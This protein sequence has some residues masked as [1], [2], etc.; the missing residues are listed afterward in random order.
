MNSRRTVNNYQMW[1]INH[2]LFLHP[3]PRF[4]MK[5]FLF[6][7]S[8]QS[9]SI[10]KKRSPFCSSE[11]T[12]TR[13]NEIRYQKNERNSSELKKSVPTVSVSHTPTS[14]TVLLAFYVFGAMNHTTQ[15]P[16][17]TKMSPTLNQE[18]LPLILDASFPNHP[19]ESSQQ[20]QLYRNHSFFSRQQLPLFALIK[21][22]FSPVY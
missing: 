5:Q 13:C 10:K 20:W 16:I 11:H 1:C 7:T 9:Q 15:V 2:G 21:Y 22:L 8:Q 12:S 14:K 4:A 17:T 19:G 18:L 6:T 3:L